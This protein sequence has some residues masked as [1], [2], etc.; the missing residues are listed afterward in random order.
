[1]LLRREVLFGAAAALILRDSEI[2]LVDYHVHLDD[3]WGMTLE[4]ALAFSR[5]RG[6]KFGIVEHAGTKDKPYRNIISDDTGLK[7]YLAVLDGTPFYK[8]IQ[9]EGLDWMGCFTP[10]LVAQLDYVLTDALTL[11]EKDGSYTELW[12]PHV[13]V[14]NKDAFM[15]RYVNFHLQV[16]SREPIDI[17]A[18]PL[19]L[20]ACIEKEFDALW[21][22][23]R[24]RRIVSA[25]KKYNVAIEINERFRLPGTRFLKM[26]RAAGVKFSFGSNWHN[27][28]VGQMEYAAETL[29]A[30]ELKPSEIWRPAAFGR[31]PI[32]IRK[33]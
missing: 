20:P 1:M 11:P 3:R 22:D 6:V 30:L 7:R 16:I 32:Q 8:G 21:T 26:A 2:P 28:K 24:M 25:A 4:K 10:A 33:F 13:K 14:D 31:K 18:N 17:L 23:A 9:A 29:R 19:F 12:R 27:E 15:E 5:E